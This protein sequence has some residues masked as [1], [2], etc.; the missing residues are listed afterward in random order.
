MDT[1][2]GRLLQ[3]TRERAEA[4]EAARAAGAGGAAG[5]ESA[6][7][8]AAGGEALCRGTILSRAQYLFDV[9]K[10]GYLDAR[11]RPSG[12]MSPEQVEQWTAAIEDEP[13]CRD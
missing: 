13:G 12:A 3:E 2:I 5:A 8:A 9:E 4:A 1:L 7:G 10:Q 11:L 6:A